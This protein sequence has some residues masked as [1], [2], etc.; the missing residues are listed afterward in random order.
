MSWKP[1]SR[2]T[3]LRG[4]GVAVALPWLEAMWPRRQARAQSFPKRFMTYYVPNGLYMEKWIPT[5]TGANYTPSPLL[6]QLAA[7]QPDF[8]V[9]SNIANPPAFMTVTEGGGHSCGAGALLTLQHPHK[10]LGSDIQAGVSIDQIMANAWRGKTRFPSLELGSVDIADYVD[11]ESNWSSVYV[12]H[13]SWTGPSS[14]LPKEL[15]ARAA[16]DRLFNASGAGGAR[17]PSKS[18][19]DFVM[20]DAST[21]QRQ[22]G[23]TDA[24]KLDDY[25]SSVRDVE[26]Q[27]GGTQPQV[28]GEQGISADRSDLPGQVKS[29]LDVIALAFQTDSTRVITY[30]FGN[31]TS[32][33]AYG[34]LG[35]T[36][37]HHFLSH[38]DNDPAKLAK[39]ATI[40][41]WEVQQLAYLLQKLKA[42]PEGDGSVLDNSIVYFTSEIGDGQNHTHDNLPILVAGRAGGAFAPGRHV[43]YADNPPLANLYAA[44]FQALDLPQTTLAGQPTTP[45]GQLGG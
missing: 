5:N 10:T 17:P 21:L 28:G 7:V 30:M 24:H 39:I 33:A 29:M 16:F 12:R 9:L 34:F 11:G 3:M 15:N 32:G 37:P 23:S 2:R 43:A 19:L 44:F 6:Q 4:A 8:L 1:I 36:E 22:L 38:H 18:L 20:D 14:P 42:M 41:T 40:N 31:G 26:L 13:L 25:L 45:L 35:L 27:L